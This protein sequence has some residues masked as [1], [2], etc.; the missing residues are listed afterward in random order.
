MR[1]FAIRARIW[2]L[3]AISGGM[4]VLTGCDPTVR[5]Q[6]LAGVGG[7]ATDLATTFI[8]AFF[9]GLINDSQE[10]EATVV[11]AIVEELPKFFA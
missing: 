7:A 3:S 11:R 5:D 9:Q 10:E 4:F 6:V 2:M 8:G 1:I